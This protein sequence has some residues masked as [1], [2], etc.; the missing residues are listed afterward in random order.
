M[1]SSQATDRQMPPWPNAKVELASYTTIPGRSVTKT[2]E[3]LAWRDRRLIQRRTL[4]RFWV[5]YTAVLVVC[6]CATALAW[7]HT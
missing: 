2:E 5:S 1:K 3:I 6:V 7:S 4:R